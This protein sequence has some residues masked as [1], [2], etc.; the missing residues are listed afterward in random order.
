MRV[1]QRVLAARRTQA[2]RFAGEGIACN[3]QM[4]VRH[5]EEH[6]RLDAEGRKA[7]RGAFERMGLSLRGRD[8]VLKVART[9]ADLAG[10]S[11]IREE[12]VGRG[13]R[14]PGVGPA[15]SGS[16][17]ISKCWKCPWRYATISPVTGRRPCVIHSSPHIGHCRPN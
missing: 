11:D 16:C 13:G 7:L 4:T 10:E 12:H 8:R 2:R 15:G 14:V 9:L 6:C 17:L 3:A 1:R 5:I